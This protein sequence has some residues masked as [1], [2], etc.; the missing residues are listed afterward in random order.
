MHRRDFITGV[1]L[2]PPVIATL[3]RCVS[4]TS[5]IDRYTSTVRACVGIESWMHART[6]MNNGWSVRQAVYVNASAFSSTWDERHMGGFNISLA[7]HR[8]L[9]TTLSRLRTNRIAHPGEGLFYFYHSYD[10]RVQRHLFM[11][12][13]IISDDPNGN[14]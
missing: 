7:C 6:L 8:L 13:C 4:S 10:W 3:P 12:G 1:L 14:Q 11:I 5:A 9:K 2:T